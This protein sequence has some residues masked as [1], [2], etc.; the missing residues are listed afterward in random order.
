MEDKPV[1]ARSPRM[2]ER[3]QTR[4]AQGDALIAMEALHLRGEQSLK[5]LL[6]NQGL[7]LSA[8]YRPRK[9]GAPDSWKAAAVAWQRNS[10]PRAGVT[11]LHGGVLP[12]DH[13]WRATFIIRDNAVGAG[14]S[15]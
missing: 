7:Q 5:R 11:Y 12:T 4:L 9:P 15:H 1:N 2:F 8:V 13:C 10:R 6:E 3:M 14:C